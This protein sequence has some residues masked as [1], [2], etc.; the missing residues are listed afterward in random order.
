MKLALLLA[1][2]IA[3]P[4]RAEELKRESQIP[5]NISERPLTITEDT[6]G[7]T[8]TAFGGQLAPDNGY[9]FVGL[10]AD[11][12]VTDDFQLELLLVRI[13]FAPNS[14]GL[15]DPIGGLTYRLLK[16]PFELG[17]RAAMTVPFGEPVSGLLAV[18]MLVRFAPYLRLDL[19]PQA[20]ISATKPVSFRANLPVLLRAQLG[21]RMA[22][23]ASALF[24]LPDLRRSDLLARLGARFTYTI[25]ERQRADYDL[26]VFFEAPSIAFSGPN[27]D[28]YISDHYF[29]FGIE[30]RA[31]IEDTADSPF[32]EEL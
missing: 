19:A 25:G 18:P 11:Y 28:E 26:S 13:S 8:G 14:N 29:S 4:A 6:F 10:G 17:L 31:F 24:Y 15:L 12:G 30:V 21:D 20:Q 2:A 7:I 27:P 3:L 1:L 16:G 22:I 5:E 32:D 23:G 9:L